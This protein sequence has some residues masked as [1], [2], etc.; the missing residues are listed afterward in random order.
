MNKLKKSFK[1]FRLSLLFA[2]VVFLILVCTM[3]LV[4]LGALLLAHFDV[5]N[6]SN[7]QR[8]PL[9]AFCIS[10]IIIGTI[11]SAIFSKKPL[12]PMRE[13]MDA[14]DKIADGDRKSVV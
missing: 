9:F 11:I 4:I 14:T 12:R 6:S 3:V 7:F 8:I 5:L 1:Y 13:I 10:S 2:F